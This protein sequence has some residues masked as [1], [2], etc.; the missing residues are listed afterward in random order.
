MAVRLDTL[1]RIKSQNKTGKTAKSTAGIQ[2]SLALV[3]CQGLPILLTFLRLFQGLLQLSNA[4][5]QLIS[6]L[7]LPSPGLASGLG[8]P[9]TL[10]SHRVGR[11]ELDRR[12]WLAMMSIDT[13][14]S[15][16]HD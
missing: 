8:V 9:G 6:S 5:L 16:R 11:V 4:K 7:Q 14:D 3:L 13:S 15:R 12:Q 1:H 10:H 2:T